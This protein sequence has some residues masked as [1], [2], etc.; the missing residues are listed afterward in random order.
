MKKERTWI[1]FPAAVLLCVAANGFPLTVSMPRCWPGLIVCALAANLLPLFISASGNGTQLRLLTHGNGCLR[2]FVIGVILSVPLQLIQGSLNFFTDPTRWL[3]GLLVC[4]CVLAVTFW[5]GMICVYCTSVQ[6]GIKR[7][8]IGILCGMIPMVNLFV[9]GNILK[10][11]S[12]EIRFEAEKN[13][14]DRSRREQQICNT[15]Y[16]IVLVHGVFFRDTRFFNYWG[17]IPEALTRNGAQIFYGEQPSAAS[18]ADCGKFLADRIQEICRQTGSQKVNII[19]HSKGGLDCRYAIAFCGAAP[20]VASLTTVNTPHRGC[21]FADYLLDKIPQP[22]QQQVAETYNIALRK[23]GEADADFM[24]AV[25]DLTS[26]S[27]TRLDTAMPLP[28][29]I[30]CH[31]IGSK[32]NHASGGKFPLNFSYHLVRYFDGANDGLVGEDSF[33]WGPE[34]TFL[35][36]PGKEGISHG[37]MIDLNRYNL[38]GFDVREF[39]VQLV[40]DLRR[41]GL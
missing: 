40:A 23:L 25:S 5:N 35:Q 38:P 20:F 33:R 28:E 8:L 37:D 16:P 24:A 27:C 19:A 36:A 15:H 11:T 22:A 17:R 2:L 31:S 32:L 3:I 12:A 21:K 7:R 9:L 30:F 26:E 10:T 1:L 13:A 34:F 18:I 41:R 14:L 39:Y 6:L 29:G 4:V